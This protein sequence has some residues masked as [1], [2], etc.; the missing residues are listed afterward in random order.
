M[1]RLEQFNGFAAHINSTILMLND[2][3]NGLVNDVKATKKR[4]EELDTAMT[5]TNNRLN[6]GISA[7][8]ARVDKC[9]DKHHTLRNMMEDVW[10][11]INKQQCLM[12]NMDK[13]ISFYSSAVA[14]LEGK[15]VEVKNRFN[16]LEQHITGQDD[17]I[18]ILLHH[19]AAAEEGHCCCQESTP[20][21][22]SCHY[23]NTITKLTEDVQETMVEL[24]TGGL[25]YEDEEVEAFCCSLILRN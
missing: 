1:L 5:T 19:L 2:I 25:E 9:K 23:F 7:L 24:E 20:K 18:K 6:N 22:I 10:A 11:T 14:Q 3:W 17:Q 12:Y 13:R 21:V 8:D 16:V 15:K 4:Y